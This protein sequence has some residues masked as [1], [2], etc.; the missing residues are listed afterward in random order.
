MI[1]RAM[2]VVGL[3]CLLNAKSSRGD[4]ESQKMLS[5]NVAN[6]FESLVKEDG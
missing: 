4:S 6:G 5:K 2:V 3:V 1:H